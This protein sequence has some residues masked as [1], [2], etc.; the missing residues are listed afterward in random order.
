MKKFQ[1]E[2][3]LLF[4]FDFITIKLHFSL[5]LILTSIFFLSLLNSS[6]SSYLRKYSHKKGR[7]TNNLYI[8]FSLLDFNKK[9]TFLYNLQL[10][11]KYPHESMI[12]NLFFAQS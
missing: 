1:F 5:L 7:Y 4:N 10:L 12:T 3:R 9:L 2:K 11:H 6:S 8:V